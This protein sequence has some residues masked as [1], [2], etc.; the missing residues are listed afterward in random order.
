MALPISFDYGY[1]AP[2]VDLD[3]VKSF[4][5]NVDL[6]HKK[7]TQGGG[8]GDDFLGWV[9]PAKIVSARRSQDDQDAGGADPGQ[10]GCP[11]LHRHRRVLSRARAP[12][13]RRW[14]RATGRKSSSPATR[15]PRT[16]IT[17]FLKQLDGKRFSI[18]AISKSGTT[19]EPAVAF[20]LFRDLLEKN[21]RQGRGQ[22]AHRRHDRRQERRAAQVRR[23][24]RLR[25][26]EHRR[27]CR[28]ALLRSQPGRPAADRR[29]RH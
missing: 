2:D 28:R 4:Q 8:L 13:S 3:E 14:A 27:R 15:C 9:D 20:R 6:A 21:G 25:D 29:R 22:E 26:P 1:L 24:R 18:N 16:S 23:G 12:S 19:T 10:L 17:K 11:G 7:V 5:D